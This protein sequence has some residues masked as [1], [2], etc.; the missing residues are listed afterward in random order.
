MPLLVRWPDRV[1]AG[2]RIRTPVSLID[3]A[4]TILALTGLPADPAHQGRSLARTMQTGEEPPPQ[5]IL[6]E[7][8]EYGPDRFL[9]REGNIKVVLTPYPDRF[10]LVPIPAR[11]LE[12]FDLATDPLERHDLSTHLTKP[13]AE[14]VDVLW[15]RA[16]R[17]LSGPVPADEGRPPLPEDL[18]Q[19]L[20]SLGYLH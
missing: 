13:V 12:V 2:S 8:I 1:P 6:A 17:V 5:P 20:R 14:M 9:I 16:K 3:L 11:P 18:L 19:Q 7:A 4:P 10:N 15:R